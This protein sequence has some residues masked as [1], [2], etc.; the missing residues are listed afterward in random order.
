MEGRETGGN[1]E[2]SSEGRIVFAEPIV[3]LRPVLGLGAAA[4]RRVRVH[5]RRHHHHP[6]VVRRPPR[7]PGHH[8][9]RV[10]SVG[11]V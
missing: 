3:I 1:D 2:P 4:V 10:L 8:G 7:L 9:V 6:Q 11:R 5:G